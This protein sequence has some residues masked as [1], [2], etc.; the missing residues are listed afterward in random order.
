MH[1]AY[2]SAVMMLRDRV[3]DETV[4]MIVSTSSSCGLRPPGRDSGRGV[5]WDEP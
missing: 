1:A 4:V 2:L 5:G 3:Q